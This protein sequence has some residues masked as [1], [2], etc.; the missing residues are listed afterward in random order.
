MITCYDEAEGTC[1]EGDSG[2]AGKGSAVA[3]AVANPGLQDL[4]AAAPRAAPNY[5]IKGARR[6]AAG[7][8]AHTFID[9]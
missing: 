9:L 6:L 7:A 1:S 3:T 4:L 2:G 8:P 5:A